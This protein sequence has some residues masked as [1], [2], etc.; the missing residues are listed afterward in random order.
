MTKE[1]CIKQ[2]E[3]HISKVRDNICQIGILLAYAGMH[4]DQSKLEEPELS[5]FMECTEKLSKLTYGSEA[6]KKQLEEMQTFLKHHYEENTHHPEHHE[7]GIEQMTLIDL[8]EMFC[9]W[10]AATTRHDDG[11]IYKSIRHNEERFNIPPQLCQI[12]RNTVPLM[13]HYADTEDESD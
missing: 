9:D 7:K 11:N 2:T 10:C 3:E 13:K 4:H 6:Y 1:E 5:G 12:F 8:V